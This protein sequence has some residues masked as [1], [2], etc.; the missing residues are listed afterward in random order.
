MM[1]KREGYQLGLFTT[2]LEEVVPENHF[3]RQLEATIDFSFVYEALAPYYCADNGRYSIDPV[4]IVKQLLIGFLYGINSERRLEEECKYNVA[5]RWFLG[6]RFDERIPD[7][8]TISQLRRRKFNDAEVFK[9]LFAHVLRLCVDAGLVSGRLLLTDSSHVKAN[10]S[11]TSKTKVMVERETKAYFERLDAYEAEE[12]ERLEMPGITRKTP[13]PKQTEQTKST[14]DAETGWLCRPGKPE[15]FHY[16]AHQ[17]IDAE[18]GIIV[19][20]V[21]TAGNV[22]DHVPYLEQINRSVETLEKM[23]IKTQ[24]VA[25]DAAYDTAAIHKELEA[26]G[27]AIYMPKRETADNSKAE[28]KRSDFI[29]DPERDVFICPMGQ[30]LTLGCL[31]RTESGVSREYRA[32]SKTCK[33]C[34]VKE[35]CLAPSQKTR[36]ILV[37]VLQPIVDKHHEVDGTPEYHDALNQRQIWCEGTFANQKSQHNLKQLLRRGLR[38]ANDHCLLSAC[39]VNLKRLIKCHTASVQ[40]PVEV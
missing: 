37:N 33:K 24:A 35:K 31:Q 9:K 17:T 26:H 36:K 40:Y 20:V 30:A 2:S 6:L 22:S 5:Y 38:A 4:I 19:D 14:T 21:A 18:N 10:A 15:G 27:V 32:T 25:A 7:H 39:A 16:L 34:L 8:S 1:T 12:R 29:Y 3:L 23:D 13:K 28:F 11:Q